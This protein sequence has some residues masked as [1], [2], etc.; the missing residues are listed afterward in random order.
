MSQRCQITFESLTHIS[1][2]DPTERL[3]YDLPHS[4]L[5]LQTVQWL[6]HVLATSPK[7]AQQQAFLRVVGQNLYEL[8]FPVGDADAARSD[9]ELKVLRG[10]LSVNIS[11]DRSA[12]VL[13]GL[14]WEFLYV[15]DRKDG[16]GGFFLADPKRNVSIARLVQG[17]QLRQPQ[18]PLKIYVAVSNPE[19]PRPTV[20]RKPLEDFLDGL[21]QDCAKQLVLKWAPPNADWDKLKADIA[22]FK[23]DIFHFRGH[24]E[25]GGL[26]LTKADE[27]VRAARK[28]IQDA[29]DDGSFSPEMFDAGE[30]TWTQGVARLFEEHQPSLV[31]LEA[32][33]SAVAVPDVTENLVAARIAA[34]ILEKVP[35]V[36]AMQYV[37]NIVSAGQF[38]EHLYRGIVDGR[39]VDAAVSRARA[40]LT[41]GRNHTK[42]FTDRAFGAPVV[43]LGSQGPLCEPIFGDVLTRCPDCGD[44]Q[45][46]ETKN[47][48]CP[49]CGTQLYFSCSRCHK[50]TA[51]RKPNEPPVECR[52]CNLAF[53]EPG[54]G[55]GPASVRP[56]VVMTP[57]APPLQQPAAP[58]WPTA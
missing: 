15:P 39:D 30:L 18:K 20:L 55:F 53:A 31:V 40:S 54:A 4:A 10:D 35:A 32:C 41:Q 7:D 23:P 25:R 3:S 12:I 24:G 34:R 38:V 43:Y 5:L 57:A 13:A 28:R 33:E 42:N 11:F 50:L 49:K 8:I 52:R 51:N 27:D 46:L 6:A 45:P 26:W 17:M 16:S 22:D 37:V 9:F 14:P 56:G 48:F 29:Q 36:V 19:G 58:V 47:N 44:D 21:K 2:S 1:Y